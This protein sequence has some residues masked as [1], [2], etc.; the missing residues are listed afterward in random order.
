MVDIPAS[1]EDVC[2]VEGLT[3]HQPRLLQTVGEGQ[4]DEG[5]ELV[6]GPGGVVGE[7]LL[8]QTQVGAPSI[9]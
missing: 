5:D 1:V 9:Q 3:L 8:L 6:R 7:L 4:S 2:E